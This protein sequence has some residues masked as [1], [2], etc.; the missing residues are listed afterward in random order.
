MREWTILFRKFELRRH[1]SCCNWPVSVRDQSLLFTWGA[2]SKDLKGDH[3]IFRGNVR[4]GGQASLTEYKREEG[5][6]CRKLTANEG[7]GVVKMLQSL[8]GDHVH[9]PCHNQIPPTSP[10][11]KKRQKKNKRARPGENN[12]ISFKSYHG[13][14]F[15][16][17][18]N[19]TTIIWNYLSAGNRSFVTPS[20]HLNTFCW[21]D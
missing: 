15:L 6:S 9:S 13:V 14:F 4:G 3:M 2:G 11:D 10:S 1:I 8:M 12:F 7:G 18:R 20:W 5:R 21:L 17:E 16:F 19:M